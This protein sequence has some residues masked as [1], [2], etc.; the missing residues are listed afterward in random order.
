MIESSQPKYLNVIIIKDKQNQAQ[1]VNDVTRAQKK[2]TLQG[3]SSSTSAQTTSNLP[4]SLNRQIDTI[5]TKSNQLDSS[6]ST[7]Y[8]I[9]KQLK[10]T[11]AQISILELLK[12]SS[13]HR[14][15]L[16]KAL[17][18]TNVPKDLYVNQFQS[19][20]GHLTSPHY[21]TFSKEY[22]NSLNH[23]HN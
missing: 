8:S 6:S 17:L 19:M 4:T 7:G 20:V 2:V 13:V 10:R 22:D 15:I 23:P 9:V 14:E 18:T 3:A 5:T 1:L 16:D 21:L 11:N 12:I